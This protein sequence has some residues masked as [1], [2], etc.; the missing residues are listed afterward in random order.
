MN[1]DILL[2]FVKVF[3]LQIEF[4]LILNSPFMLRQPL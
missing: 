1:E 4:L 3:A 2:N